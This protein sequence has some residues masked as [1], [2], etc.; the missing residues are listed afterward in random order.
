MA[1][2][3]PPKR[4][5]QLGFAD[6]GDTGS[7]MPTGPALPTAVVR[8]SAAQLANI[9]GG[10]GGGAP[11]LTAP[12]SGTASP[13]VNP[14]PLGTRLGQGLRAGVQGV[15]NSQVGN[16]NAALRVGAGAT[17]TMTSGLRAVG[18]L[19]RDAGLAAGGFNPAQN[20]GQAIGGI[21]AP[22]LQMPYRPAPVNFVAGAQPGPMSP[23]AVAKAP[24]TAMAVTPPIVAPNNPVAAPKPVIWNPAASTIPA[25][26]NISASKLAAATQFTPAP[27]SQIDASVPGMG[28]S[29]NTRLPYGAVV[30]GVP[31]FSDGSGRIPQT[32]SP[33]AMAQLAQGRSLSRADPGALG[34]ALASDG[35]GGTPTQDQMVAQNVAQGQLTQPVTGFRPSAEMFADADRQAIAM[36]DPRSAAGIAARNLSVDAQYGSSPQLRRVAADQLTALQA[37]TDA[38]GAAAQKAEGDQALVYSQ[39]QNELANTALAGRNSLANT[40]LEIQKAQLT[41]SGHPVTQA[42]GTLGVMDPITAAVTTA[43]NADGSVAKTLMAKDDAASRR[44]NE[45]MDQLSKTAAELGKS[46]LPPPGA[47]AGWQP[48]PSDLRAQAARYAGLPVVKNKTGQAMVNINDQWVEL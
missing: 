48:N 14:Q 29:G 24:A 39:G 13:D 9:G 43:K 32:M 20:A 38:G 47:P 33:A 36:K 37:G 2:L 42:D 4:L 26:D 6:A 25:A 21:T 16:I 7:A 30:N 22:Q 17:N 40:G 5:G 15:V 1:I 28:A 31:T 44:T 45:I 27:V 18:G 35:A 11:Q 3:Q 8:P 10:S 46:Q 23:S 19:A 41:R 34:H 12:P